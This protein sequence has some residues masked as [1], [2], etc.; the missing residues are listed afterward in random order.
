MEIFNVG[1]FELFFI[2]LIMLIVLG[3]RDMV[4]TG[5]RLGKTIHNLVRSP[6]WISMMNASRELRDL[7]TKLVRESGLEEELS[8]VRDQAQIHNLG[9]NFAGEIDNPKPAPF[10][11]PIEEAGVQL[12]SVDPP[13]EASGPGTAEIVDAA[14]PDNL[15]KDVSSD[16]NQE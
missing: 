7:P 15:E 3:P 13:I 9:L 6:T 10:S 14:H 1:P 2:L 12:A 16:L 5:Q 11:E 8:Q 4:K